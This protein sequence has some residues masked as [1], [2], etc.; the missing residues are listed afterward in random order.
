MSEANR[1]KLRATWVREYWADPKHYDG[2]D[3]PQDMAALDARA[4]WPSGMLDHE[5]SVF[6]VTV[7]EVENV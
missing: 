1:V 6:T 2:C 7:V 5:E 4:E 3:T